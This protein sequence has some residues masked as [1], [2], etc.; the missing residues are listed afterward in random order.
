MLT[1]TKIENLELA[2]RYPDWKS[3]IQQLGDKAPFVLAI[4]PALTTIKTIS[5]TTR[6]GPSSG[7][8]RP[9]PS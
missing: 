2:E 3:L 8:R 6:C 9:V 5:C 4:C 1:Y 7:Q